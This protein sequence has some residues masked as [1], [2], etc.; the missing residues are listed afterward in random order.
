MPAQFECGL[1]YRSK[2]HLADRIR[3]LSSR[4]SQSRDLAFPGDRHRADDWFSLRSAQIFL[5]YPLTPTQPTAL[6]LLLRGNGQPE[7]RQLPLTRHVYAPL[8][9]LIGQV[10]SLAVLAAIDF[11]V[12]PPGFLDATALLFGCVGHVEP[13][14]QMTAAELPLI[15]FLVAGPLAWFLDFD[16]VLGKLRKRVRKCGL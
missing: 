8:L 6:L 1:R 5:D 11:H 16:F 7:H 3:A 13:A 2:N 12:R 4:A 14:L 10:Q 15:V 9:M